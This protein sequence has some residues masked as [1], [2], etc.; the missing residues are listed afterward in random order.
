[1]V[2]VQI[3][4][5]VISKYDVAGQM[6]QDVSAAVLRNPSV[7]GTI[8][9]FWGLSFAKHPYAGSTSACPFLTNASDPRHIPHIILK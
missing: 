3:P 6:H 5:E 9:G 7:Y 8:H 1:M 4:L 2:V